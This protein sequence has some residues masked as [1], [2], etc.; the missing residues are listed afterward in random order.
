MNIQVCCR[1][2]VLLALLLIGAQA[3]AEPLHV[4]FGMD[5]SKLGDA[6]A[7][8]RIDVIKLAL[9][10]SGEAYDFRVQSEHMNQA[11]RL[12]FLQSGHIFNVAIQGTSPTF[13]ARFLPV[14]VPIYLGL[15]SG[16]R[17]ML[18]RKALEP[19]L[20][21]VKTLQDLRRF[22]IGQG[23]SWSDI[24]IWRNAG[25]KVVESSYRNLFGMTAR[26]RFDLFSRGLFEAYEEQRIYS[27]QYPD[28]VVDDGLLVVYP[29]AVYIFVSPNAPGIHAALLKGMQAA[30][31]NGHLQALLTSNAAV[32]QALAQAHLDSRTQIDLPAYDMTPETL[33]ALRTYGFK[34]P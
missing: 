19:E 29:F 10:E 32:E 1:L 26:G 33:E 3:R 9:E 28:L 13:E 14:R 27:R 17:L 25:F 7:Q 24:P 34:F 6:L 23:S 30:Y 5:K 11:R 31:A 22:S 21:R 16:S 12:N 15:G 20:A 18:T 8:Y 4:V 2:F